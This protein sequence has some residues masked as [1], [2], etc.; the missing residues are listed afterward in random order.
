MHMHTYILPPFRLLPGTRQHKSTLA[1]LSSSS[2]TI[3]F[4][5]T[6]AHQYYLCYCSIIHLSILSDD[7]TLQATGAYTGCDRFLRQFE[8]LKRWELCVWFHHNLGSISSSIIGPIRSKQPH[9]R[10]RYINKKPLFYCNINVKVDWTIERSFD[11]SIYELV[12]W[13]A[14]H[15]PSCAWTWVTRPRKCAYESLTGWP[16][17][18][19][20]D[21]W[22]CSECGKWSSP[23]EKMAMCSL[24]DTSHR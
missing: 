2:S 9:F 13:W 10:C 1:H 3:Y 22:P 16:S 8:S 12:L 24:D 19:E 20:N 15:N 14:S 21:E 11:H 5:T 4:I 6:P 18:E 17:L 7:T 23:T